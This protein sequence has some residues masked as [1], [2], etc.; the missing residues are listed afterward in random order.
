MAML[1]QHTNVQPCCTEQYGFTLTE[2]IVVMV[3]MA[4]LMAAAL[5][6]FRGPKE[7]AN[8][9]MLSSAAQTYATAIDGFKRDHAS[10]APV[11]SGGPAADRT[12]DWSSNTP[13]SLKN[14]PMD[15]DIDPITE[16][17]ALYI[18]GGLPDAVSANRVVIRSADY[19]AKLEGNTVGALS[20]I[21][22]APAA[23]NEYALVAFARKVGSD[24]A[25]MFCFAGSRD[26]LDSSVAKSWP[27]LQSGAVPE[28]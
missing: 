8:R 26:V 24:D 20:Y 14:G 15:S 25:A 3:V 18:K 6:S 11:V 22:G 27:K 23:P 10:R 21:S 16:K 9:K 19:P 17:R 2:V 13:G 7:S 28:C 12:V 5:S 1:T 4:I